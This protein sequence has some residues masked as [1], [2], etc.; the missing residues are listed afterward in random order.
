MT[1]L[2]ARVKKIKLE[3]IKFHDYKIIKKISIKF[4]KDVLCF[5]CLGLDGLV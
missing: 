4:K 3:Q 1:G 2:C 5:L